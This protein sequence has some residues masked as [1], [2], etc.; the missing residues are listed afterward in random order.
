MRDTRMY[1]HAHKLTYIY[2]PRLCNS[3]VEKTRQPVRWSIVVS[4]CLPQLL[5]LAS[6]ANHTAKHSRSLMFYD[7]LVQLENP[8]YYVTA[9]N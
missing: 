6:V 9:K 5:Q 7:V 3:T 8:A 4:I 1:L 2:A